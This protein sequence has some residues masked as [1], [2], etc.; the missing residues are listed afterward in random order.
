[1]REQTLLSGLQKPRKPLRVIGAINGRF[2]RKGKAIR[3]GRPAYEPA[4]Q[5]NRQ[6][7]S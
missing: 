5:Q 6:V 2:A 7:M 4:A 3:H 1:M